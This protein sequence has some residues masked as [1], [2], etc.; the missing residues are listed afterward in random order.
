MPSSLMGHSNSL[1]AGSSV[2]QMMQL[3]VLGR[4]LFSYL[5]YLEC[6]RSL[7]RLALDVVI[8]S[9]CCHEVVVWALLP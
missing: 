8:K 6:A 2:R 7:N 3:W 1:A 9:R 4:Q 5:N